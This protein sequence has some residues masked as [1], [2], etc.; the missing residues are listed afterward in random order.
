MVALYCALTGSSVVHLKFKK[1]RLWVFCVS[2]LKCCTFRDL[3][4]RVE[5]HHW[6]LSQH[7]T[8]FPPCK[9][10]RAGTMPVGWS[11][12]M[13]CWQRMVFL[14]EVEMILAISPSCSQLFSLCH[15]HH[16]WPQVWKPVFFPP[17]PVKRQKLAAPWLPNVTL[18]IQYIQNCAS[19][20]K[21]S[22]SA[23]GK[24]VLGEFLGCLM[25]VC[26]VLFLL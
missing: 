11:R 14:S 24:M 26:P 12:L 5:L 9:E 3:I 15:H 22:H 10:S 17:F 6:R 8:A 23:V 25:Y 13:S 20:D 19:L 4:S 21:N 16:H 18:A 1:F 7:D 2:P